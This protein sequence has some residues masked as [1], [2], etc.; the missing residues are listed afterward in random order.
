MTSTLLGFILQLKRN[1][2]HIVPCNN[3][4]LVKIFVTIYQELI[5]ITRL[6]TLEYQGF[7]IYELAEQSMLIINHSQSKY[8][9]WI[10][11]YFHSLHLFLVLLQLHIAMPWEGWPDQFQCIQR[12]PSYPRILTPVESSLKTKAP[13]L[14]HLFLAPYSMKLSSLLLQPLLLYLMHSQG[15]PMIGKGTVIYALPISQLPTLHLNGR[16]FPSSFTLSTSSSRPA[17]NCG[18]CSRSSFLYKWFYKCC[19][20]CS[21]GANQQE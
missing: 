15:H 2:L 1:K 11:P 19:Y 8:L 5:Y 3:T 17:S 9:L 10:N 21:G 12:Q 7:H 20:C 6:C 16:C 13:K 14:H 4:Y 18:L